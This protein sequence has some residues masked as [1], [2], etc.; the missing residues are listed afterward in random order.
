MMAIKP[1]DYVVNI[2]K[3]S[4]PDFQYWPTF[5][6]NFRWHIESKIDWNARPP[7]DPVFS[8]CKEYLA[9]I[10]A[11]IKYTKNDELILKFKDE[12]DFLIFKLKW[13]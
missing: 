11:E 2:D 6:Y 10:D 4:T 12:A 1:N 5:W 7:A 3:I 8:G 9:K 13:S